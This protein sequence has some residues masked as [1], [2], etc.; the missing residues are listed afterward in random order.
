M[1]INTEIK[2]RTLLLYGSSLQRHVLHQNMC[3]HP[4]GLS[5]TWLCLDNH[6]MGLSCIETCLHCR[7]SCAAPQRVNTQGPELHLDLS[8]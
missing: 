7:E 6:H 8:G 4:Q 3:L 1:Q 5:C 2:T